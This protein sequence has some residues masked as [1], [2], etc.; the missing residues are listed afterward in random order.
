[1]SIPPPRD[2]ASSHDTIIPPSLPNTA[3][4]DKQRRA[5]GVCVLVGVAALI[6]MA[7][8]VGSGLL[9]GGLTAF[10][11]QPIHERL[12]RRWGSRTAALVCTVGST[13][14]LSLLLAGLGY[15]LIAKGISA[16]GAAPGLLA[17]GAPLRM[18][19]ERFGGRLSHLPIPIHPQDL[20]DKLQQEAMKLGTEAAGL[21]ANLLAML[22]Y[23]LFTLFFVAITTYFV[24][25]SWERLALAAEVILPIH[26]RHTRSVFEQLRDVGR[27]V[28]L[29]TL[30]TALAQGLM[31]GLGYW[32]CGAPQ[33]AF[34]GVLTSMASLVPAVGTMLV[35]VPLGAY[36]ILTGHMVAG[37]IL[38]IFGAFVVVGF[39][40]Y[41]LRPYLVGDT[42]TVPALLT[43]VSL[44]GGIEV[45]GLLGLVIGPIV[46]TL[47][48][49]LLR[50]YHAEMV[51]RPDAA[52]ADALST[53]L[54]RPTRP[55][56]RRVSAVVPVTPR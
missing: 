50:T 10:S 52:R 41:F 31:A 56:D 33:P 43:F 22:L 44:F 16:V 38:F 25:R 18:Q 11:L 21:V 53:A 9:L 24:L 14:A 54:A 46:V 47:T 29:G 6:W 19:I 7:L 27:H 8:P 51:A 26:P 49:A 30:L 35:W 55:D 3:S 37:V 23:T 20:I 45:F 39:S 5:L 12:R 42:E 1:L 15:V 32:V 34:F 40:D 28:F 36:L 17:P 13:T 48:V 4:T 2:A